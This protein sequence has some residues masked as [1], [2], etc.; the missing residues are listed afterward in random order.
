MSYIYFI[1]MEKD[2]GRY[3]HFKSLHNI[4][5]GNIWKGKCVVPTDKKGYILNKPT[6]AMCTQAAKEV[7]VE[8]F[9]HFLQNNEKDT[10]LVIFEDDLIWHK[11]FENNFRLILDNIKYMSEWKLIYLGVSSS[12]DYDHKKDRINI[13]GSNSIYLSALNVDIKIYTGA[14]GVIINKSIL[15]ELLNRA[16]IPELN[17]KPFD[18][19]CLGYIQK[20]YQGQCFLSHPQQI[21]ADVSGSNIR[22]NRDQ[23]KFNE[24]MN[25]NIKEYIIPTKI[26]FLILVDN[27]VSRIKRFIYQCNCLTPVIQLHLILTTKPSTEMI[28]FILKCKKNGVT[29]SVLQ[30]NKNRDINYILKHHIITNNLVKKNEYKA[31]FITN[32]YVSWNNSIKEDTF[33]NILNILNSGAID[34]ILWELTYC[35]RCNNHKKIINVKIPYYTLSCIKITSFVQK[36]LNNMNFLS[37]SNNI[38]LSTTCLEISDNSFHNLTLDDIT[39]SLLN[40]ENLFL[41]IN[42]KQKYYDEIVFVD[43]ILKWMHKYFYKTLLDLINEKYSVHLDNCSI[44]T[45][46]KYSLKFNT[47]EFNVLKFVKEIIPNGLV[48]IMNRTFIKNTLGVY[49]TPAFEHICKKSGVVIPTYTCNIVFQKETVIHYI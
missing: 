10:H 17:G 28:D 8:I 26:P 9:N 2:V 46:K 20:K 25:W 7:K 35:D 36:N 6:Q 30:Y 37:L 49:E 34:G 40:V 18:A 14:Y 43:A 19:T 45:E 48:F 39:T 4:L 16:A 3:T 22:D 1:H 23:K 42:Y 29:S 13:K 38:Y 47:P 44:I 5:G 21:L 24:K 27:N 32:S 33:S 41:D 31:M 15:H 11:D 12:V